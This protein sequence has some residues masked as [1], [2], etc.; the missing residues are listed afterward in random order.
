MSQI[1][2]LHPSSGRPAAE[3]VAPAFLVGGTPD[4]PERVPCA[5]FWWDFAWLILEGHKPIET[6]G[7]PWPYPPAGWLVIF[8]SLGRG[9]PTQRPILPLGV[10][11][12]EKEACPRQCLTGLIWIGSSRPLVEAD[13]A[14]ACFYEP[15]RWAWMIGHVLR[16]P[17]PVPR[18]HSGLSSSPQG[19]VYLPRATVLEALAG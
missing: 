9:K 19:I 15:G 17:L 2:F 7:R 3:N 6:R 14:A 4:L 1:D 10:E 5:P 18:S 12:P 16:F 8:S 11:L 13:R